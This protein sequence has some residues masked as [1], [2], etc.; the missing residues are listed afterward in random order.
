MKH[1]FCVYICKIFKTSRKSNFFLIGGTLSTSV[2]PSPR[3]TDFQILLTQKA[4]LT[5]SGRDGEIF[6]P[7]VYPSD[8]CHSQ[9]PAGP[10]RREWNSVWVFC[11]HSEAPS[12]VAFLGTLAGS[13]VWSEHLGRK[14]CQVVSRVSVSFP[15]CHNTAAPPQVRF[16]YL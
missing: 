11:E 8:S 5:E 10:K 16:I 6:Y 1:Y 13:R 3:N 4:E 15:L 7:L 9:D 12:S 2:S 14:G